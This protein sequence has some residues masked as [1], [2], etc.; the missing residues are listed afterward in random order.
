MQTG[1]SRAWVVA[2]AL[3]LVLC[4]GLALADENVVGGCPV[5]AGAPQLDQDQV[6]ECSDAGA[7]VLSGGTCR[8]GPSCGQ[9]SA[10][11]RPHA[12]A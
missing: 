11:E 1:H 4:A 7:A 6:G 9:G 12:G 2:A 5:L 8:Q 3:V 10:S